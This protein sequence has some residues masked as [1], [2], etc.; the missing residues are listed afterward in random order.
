M[1]QQEILFRKTTFKLLSRAD[2]LKQS[3]NSYQSATLTILSS[4]I[5]LHQ[6]VSSTNNTE[7]AHQLEEAYAVHTQRLLYKQTQRYEKAMV[8]LRTRLDQWSTVIQDWHQ[9]A[10]DAQRHAA[11]AQA[12]HLTNNTGTSNNDN[13]TAF[14]PP[15]L[16]S[17]SLIQVT[18]V[19]PAQAHQWILQ[20]EDMY[21][22]LYHCKRMLFLQL[23]DSTKEPDMATIMDQWSNEKHH[24]QHTITQDI[25][26][27]LHLYNHIKK[28][29]ESL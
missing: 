14:T 3:W 2:A 1:Q 16:S 21:K 4:L 27:R 22:R 19:S 17:H 24:H 11:K 15:P 29:I 13:H 20:L 9:L 10:I 18:S 8:Q 5:N 6:Q 12:I 26:D 7:A 23:E 28:V 25:S